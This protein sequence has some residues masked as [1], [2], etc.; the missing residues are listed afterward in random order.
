MLQG[1]GGVAD[2]QLF[3]E[4]AHVRVEAGAR[5]ANPDRLAEALRSAGVAVESV[6]R[7]P[8]SLEDIF[9]ARVAR[10]TA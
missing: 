7:V 3:G 10:E 1:L 4:R 2:V 6:R 8:A 9:I 5:L